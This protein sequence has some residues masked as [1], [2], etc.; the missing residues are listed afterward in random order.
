MRGELVAPYTRLDH[1]RVSVLMASKHCIV[2]INGISAAHN[3][4]LEHFDATAAYIP[5]PYQHD[6][7][8]LVKIPTSRWLL[9]TWPVHRASHKQPLKKPK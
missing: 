6:K 9:Q 5:E 1:T 8:V 4:T 2:P 3:I 7:P